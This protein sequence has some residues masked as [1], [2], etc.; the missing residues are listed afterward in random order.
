MGMGR[1]DTSAQD[2]LMAQQQ[3]DLAELKRKEE[4]EKKKAS[5]KQAKNMRRRSGG[6]LIDAATSGQSTLG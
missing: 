3:R 6:S 1:P 2:A 4:N 5:D